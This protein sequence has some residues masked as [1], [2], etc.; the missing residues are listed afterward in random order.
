MYYHV[1]GKVILGIDA[2]TEDQAREIAEQWGHETV[3]D[4]SI[5][6]VE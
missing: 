2:D 3:F 4:F 5:T 6:G 1:H